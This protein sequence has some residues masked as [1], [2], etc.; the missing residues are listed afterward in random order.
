MEGSCLRG[1]C[2]QVSARTE[3]RPACA[4]RPARYGGLAPA[5]EP[6]RASAEQIERS[7]LEAQQR[8]LQ[9]SV[10]AMQSAAAATGGG[11]GLSDGGAKLRARMEDASGA[12]DAIEKAL[13]GMAL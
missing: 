8:Q 6:A 1:I 7:R 12:L 5:A 13:G 11:A 3:R 4:A 2:A 9:A 10:A